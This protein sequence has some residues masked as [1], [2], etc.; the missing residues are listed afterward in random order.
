M[1]QPSVIRS[2]TVAS[3]S[4]MVIFTFVLIQDMPFA[5]AAGSFSSEP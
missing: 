1:L 5:M 3:L 4:S 2:A